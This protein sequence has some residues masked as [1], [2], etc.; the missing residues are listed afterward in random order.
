[1]VSRKH[2]HLCASAAQPLLLAAAGGLRARRRRFRPATSAVRLGD[3][4]LRPVRSRRTRPPAS[5]PI[6][7]DNPAYEPW[8]TD[9]KPDNGK[10][11]ESA[12]AYAVAEQARLRQR[13]T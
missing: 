9:N 8:F 6:G 13:T 12:V 2:P 4:V 7:T 1:M 5:S 10:G 11:F 3:A